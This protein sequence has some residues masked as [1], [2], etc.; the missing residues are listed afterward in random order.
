MF[1]TIFLL[2]MENAIITH[3]P[4]LSKPSNASTNPTSMKKFMFHKDSGLMTLCARAHAPVGSKVARGVPGTCIY[5]GEACKGN[6][7]VAFL[8]D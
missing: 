7:G 8:V 2:Y 5:E 4:C 3:I 6:K 1:L